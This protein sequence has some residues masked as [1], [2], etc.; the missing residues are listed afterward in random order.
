ML[1]KFCEQQDLTKMPF[2]LEIRPVY[3]DKCFTKPAMHVSFK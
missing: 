3:G 2:T 1:F